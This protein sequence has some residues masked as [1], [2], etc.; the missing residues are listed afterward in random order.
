MSE[1]PCLYGPNLYTV[2]SFEIDDNFSD[3]T[4]TTIISL[5]EVLNET[6]F[7]YIDK[8]IDNNYIEFLSC[9]LKKI[10]DIIGNT[11]IDK[12]YYNLIKFLDDI[13]RLRSLKKNIRNFDIK[14]DLIKNK[15]KNNLIAKNYKYYFYNSIN[16][17]FNTSFNLS[18][19]YLNKFKYQDAKYLLNKKVNEIFNYYKIIEYLNNSLCINRAADKIIKFI[20]NINISKI[21]KNYFKNNFYFDWIM[22][23][24]FLGILCRDIRKNINLTNEKQTDN[25]KLFNINDYVIYI[26]NINKIIN[27]KIEICILIDNLDIKSKIVI[28]KGYL[29]LENK[30]LL[31]GVIFNDKDELLYKGSI[32]F[33]SNYFNYYRFINESNN[34]LLINNIS[35]DN[36]KDNNSEFY[37]SKLTY[38][39]FKFYKNN[40][41]NF[42]NNILFENIKINNK[43]SKSNS[44]S[45]ESFN[46]EE[47]ND[48]IIFNNYKLF[49]LKYEFER[50]NDS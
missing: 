41:F 46:L 14:K 5:N 16:Y 39:G 21:Y 43:T 17:Y 27:N 9:F 31:Y 4:M 2:K 45:Y 48:E 13:E 47:V 26:Q 25:E 11:Y 38:E 24:K 8:N 12:L 19:Y 49:N 30:V 6:D 23:K 32:N 40:I 28:F 37:Y 18:N 3:I 10:L 36:L 50:L 20:T 22:K 35:I 29:D 7:N 34:K 42:S 15:K 1:S 33:F 44:R